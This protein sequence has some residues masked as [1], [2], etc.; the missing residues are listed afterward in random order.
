[1]NLMGAL[2]FKGFVTQYLK[3][4]SQTNTLNLKTLAR[5]AEDGNYRLA[6]PL[7]LYAL[8]TEKKDALHPE[9]IRGGHTDPFRQ[10][11][12]AVAQAARHQLPLAVAVLAAAGR[13]AMA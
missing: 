11:G 10:I 6:A 1:M 5:E 7:V 3:E 2:T 9:A 13:E 4:L 8:A 12:N